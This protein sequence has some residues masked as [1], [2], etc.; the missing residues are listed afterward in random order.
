M[1]V[2]SPGQLEADQGRGVLHA[3]QPVRPFGPSRHAREIGPLVLPPDHAP[4]LH[5]PA[6][7]FTLLVAK[8][9]EWN[10]DLDRPAAL[11][12]PGPR[13]PDR[14]PV[15]VRGLVH[16][17]IVDARAERVRV[18]DEPVPVVVEC[19]ERQPE[20]VVLLHLERV[21][22]VVV[23]DPFTLRRRVPALRRQVDVVGVVHHP[24]FGF[25]RRR[26]PLVWHLLDKIRERRHGLEDGFVEASV[27]LKRLCK[28]SGA[29]HCVPRR[30]PAHHVGRRRTV[31]VGSAGRIRGLCL[32]VRSLVSRGDARPDE[33][34]RGSQGAGSEVV[35]DGMRRGAHPAGGVCAR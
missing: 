20:R 26:F 13:V 18:K 15:E 5:A 22:P 24:D 21:A 6:L 14:V 19:V 1:F 23:R 3:R 4:E 8:R 17:G 9:L 2:V 33:A 27:E 31:A 28:S 32:F 10:R 30:V 29:D 16:D 35:Q 34:E 7:T 11:E 25:L 12:P